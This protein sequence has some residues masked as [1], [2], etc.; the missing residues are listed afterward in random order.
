M[1]DFLMTQVKWH[2]CPLAFLTKQNLRWYQHE[3][4]T[5][6]KTS[7]YWELNEKYCEIKVYKVYL[8]IR[9]DNSSINWEGIN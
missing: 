5:V 3:G 8:G 1:L 7:Q 6:I 9:T 2:E 4:K